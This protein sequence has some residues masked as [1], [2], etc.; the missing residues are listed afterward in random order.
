V[1][2]REI[3]DIREQAMRSAGADLDLKEFHRRML[4]GGAIRLD[5]LREQML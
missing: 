1:G 2:E 5:H 4:E 3:L